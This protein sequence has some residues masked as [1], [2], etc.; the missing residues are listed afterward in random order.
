MI[1][2]KTIT[3][4]AINYTFGAFN[5]IFLQGM[6]IFISIFIF[7]SLKTEDLLSKNIE[8][9]YRTSVTKTDS[10]LTSIKL[11]SVEFSS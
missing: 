9:C 6:K 4:V 8:L 1:T 11:S 7:S 2:T 10:F 3:K 5:I